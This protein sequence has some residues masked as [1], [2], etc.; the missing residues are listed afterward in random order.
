MTKEG[1]VA[2]DGTGAKAKGANP[3]RRNEQV[4]IPFEVALERLEAIVR[5]LEAGALTLDESLALFQEGVGL[6]RYCQQ[7][8]GEAEA[9]IDLLITGK[10]GKLELKPAKLG[11]DS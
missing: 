6:S 8:L 5:Q 10:D 2:K 3:K 4:E 7:K 1:V 9:K 11:E